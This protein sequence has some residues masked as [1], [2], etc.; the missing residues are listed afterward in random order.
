M[1][2][3]KERMEAFW[4]STSHVM[5]D[6]VK[7]LRPNAKL[8]IGPAIDEGFYYDFDTEPF[9]PKDLE[10][11]EAEMYKIIK[12]NLEFKHIFLKRKEAEKLLKDQPYKL[13]LLSEIKGNKIS[14]YKHGEFIDLCSGPLIKNTGEIKA[15]KLLSTAGA[16]WRGDSSKPM[17]QRIYGISFASESE[18]KD[19]LKRR[20]EAAKRDHVKLGKELDLFAIYPEIGSGLPIWTPKGA[21]IRQ[22]IEDFWKA[23]HRKKGYFYVYTPHIGKI[24]LWKT[25]GHLQFYKDYLYPPMQLDNEEFMMKPMNCPFHIYIYKSKQRSYKELPIKYCELG[26]VYRKELSGTLHGLGRV[27]GFTQDDAHIIC[28]PEQAEEEIE[29]LLDIVFFFLKTFGFNNFKADLSVR[30]PK[31]K[32]KYLGTDKMWALAEKSLEKALKKKKINYK[33]AEGE[34]VFYGPK[35]DIKLFD[36]L[37]R[38]WQCSTIQFDFNLPEKFNIEY[39]GEDNQK[40]RAIMIHRAMLGSLE[41]FFSILIEHYAGAF[42]TWLSPIQV[43][44]MTLT[45]KNIKYAQKIEN[46]LK[47]LDIRVETD[48]SSTT[49]QSKIRD[50]QMEKIPYMIVIGKKEEEN[51]TIAVRTRDGKVKYGIKIDDFIK[52]LQKEIQEKK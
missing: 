33:V 26:T 41:R 27:R 15:V 25:S 2:K 49:I 20:E 19:F 4:H 6:A 47:E 10:K 5:A 52:D 45:D 36:S 32:S 24:S 31:N 23:E 38:E 8:A 35:I 40:H 29:K 51:N 39:I 16:Y 46:M 21:I 42:P 37:G 18:M 34:A 28:T 22:V 3:E 13:E 9:T 7:R 48:Y 1:T 14:F 12:Q 43:K 30:D 50:S 11:I 17:L 44:I